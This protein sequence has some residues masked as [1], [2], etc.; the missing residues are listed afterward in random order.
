MSLIWLAVANACGGP[1]GKTKC[2]FHLVATLSFVFERKRRQSEGGTE[3]PD[4][5]DPEA[6]RFAGGWQMR[7]LAAAGPINLTFNGSC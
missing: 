5:T 2:R 6:V 3:A 4:H 1:T 7:A